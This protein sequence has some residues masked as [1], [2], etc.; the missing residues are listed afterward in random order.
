MVEGMALVGLLLFV[1][2]SDFSKA[3]IKP[4]LES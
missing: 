4:V 3:E 2:S 1:Y